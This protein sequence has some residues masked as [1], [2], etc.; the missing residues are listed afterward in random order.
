MTN[1][2]RYYE[3]DEALQKLGVSKTTFYDY[4]KAKRIQKRLPSGKQRGAFFLAED[5]DNIA[6]ERRG[7]AK[8]DE[9]DK[10][11]TLLRIALPKD[12]QEMH[13]FGENIMA[14]NGEH[15][16]P[17]RMI[18]QF[19]S[20]PNSEIGYVLTR[21]EHIIGYF[22]IIPLAHD[23]MMR[24][25]QRDKDSLFNQ[26]RT[27]NLR[28]EDLAQLEPGTP[29][30]IFIWEVMSDP[31][32]KTTGQRLIG[33][34]FNSLHALGKR[35]VEIEGIYTVATTRESKS[36]CRRMDME[37]INI[38]EVTQSNWTPFKWEIQRHKNWFTKNYIQALKSYKK[39]MQRLQNEAEAPAAW[40]ETDSK[41]DSRT[42]RKPA[43]SVDA[44]RQ[45]GIEQKTPSR[46]ASRPTK[47]R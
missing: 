37:A 30:D 31:R 21:D 18:Q 2:E 32:Q 5:V 17:A 35:G 1:P 13:E 33:H 39:R 40:D 46:T 47:T 28:P 36:L 26:L 45:N 16:A 38:P 43:K 29:I 22:T 7:F 34:M 8:Q 14:R 41:T 20:V 4:V 15:S 12:A 44:G 27:R 24:I 19:L 10:E 25:I 3:L 42:E 6:A 9:E 23:E 11:K